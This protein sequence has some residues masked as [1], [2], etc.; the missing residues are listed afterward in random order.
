MTHIDLLRTLIATPSPSRHEEA[1]A[2]AIARWLEAR[3]VGPERI[4]NNVFAFAEGYDPS[5]PTLLLNSHHDTV[6][7]APSYT[8]DPYDAAIEAG[9][10]YGLGSNDAGGSAVCLA[11]TFVRLRRHPLPFN[12]LLALTAEEEV[13]GENGIRALLPALADRGVRIAAAIVGEPTGMR[14]AVAERG[15]VVL[16]AETRGVSGHAARHE[17]INAI[18]RAMEDIGRLRAW[19][20]GRQSDVLG[21]V[22]LNITQIEAGKAHNVIPDLCRWVVDVRTTDA[23]TNEETVEM[24]REAVAHSSLTPRS[25][26]VRASVIS[27]THPL[28]AAARA[29]GAETFVSPTTSDM[30]LMPFPSLKIGPGDSARSH[31]ADEYITLAELDSALDLYTS[32]ILNLTRI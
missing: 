21:P 23:Y 4:H 18:Y 7:P 27:D 13:G 8:R 5:R 12:L 29:L 20:P 30:S 11:E 32:L 17:G 22:T 19:T 10:L 16:D 9:R 24:L 1:T 3:G 28:V 2:E 25:T 14:A 26:R 15:L 6:R 31:S